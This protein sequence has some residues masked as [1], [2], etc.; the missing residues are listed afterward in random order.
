MYQSQTGCQA[1]GGA[2]WELLQCQPVAVSS[3]HRQRGR[4]TLALNKHTAPV[5]KHAI[6]WREDR[7]QACS[8]IES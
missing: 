5:R 8:I 4:R 6:P 3:E 1:L 7:G 2:R